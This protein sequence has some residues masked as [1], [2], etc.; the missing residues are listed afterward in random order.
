VTEQGS[1][2]KKVYY[3][4]RR[5]CYDIVVFLYAPVVSLQSF[6]LELDS[7]RQNLSRLARIGI[8]SPNW[9]KHFRLSFVHHGQV[10]CSLRN[11]AASQKDGLNKLR[12]WGKAGCW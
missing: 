4:S 11:L 2:L 8:V 10:M 7:A 9:C 6:R 1:T 5:Y 3:Y 12:F